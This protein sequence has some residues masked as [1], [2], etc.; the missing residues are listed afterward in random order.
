MTH[1]QAMVNEKDEVGDE[2]LRTEAVLPVQFHA[3]RRRATIEPVRRLMLAML[4]DAVRC[5]QSNSEASLPAKRREFAEAQSWICS[6]DDDVFFSFTAVC[7]ALEID[8]KALRKGLLCRK[9]TNHATGSKE[10]QPLDP[11]PSPRRHSRGAQLLTRTRHAGRGSG[12]AD[13]RCK[14]L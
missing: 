3:A 10:G 5:F 13:H 11:N 12:D 6:D 7:D 9:Q 4:V 2:F 14:M 8:P 1:L